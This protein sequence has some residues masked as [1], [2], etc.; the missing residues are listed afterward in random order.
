M[1]LF[2]AA[3][4]T[5]LLLAPRLAFAQESPPSEPLNPDPGPCCGCLIF[6]INDQLQLPQ[7]KDDLVP[8]AKELNG[9]YTI[10]LAVDVGFP[11]QSGAPTSPPPSP[12][13]CSNVRITSIYLVADGPFGWGFPVKV[14]S[15]DG[16]GGIKHY[17]ADVSAATGTVTIPGFKAGIAK[18]FQIKK[19]KV[20]VKCDGTLDPATGVTVFDCSR[21]F[22]LDCGC[23]SCSSGSCEPTAKN[24]CFTVDIPVGYADGGDTS[25]TIR[26]FSNAISQPNLESVM[27]SVP[28]SVSVIRTCQNNLLPH[29]LTN[30]LVD[31]LVTTSTTVVDLKQAHD[32]DPITITQ[33]HA[34]GGDFRVTTVALVSD[35]VNGVTTNHLRADC[36]LGT[37]AIPTSIFRYQQGRDYTP[38]ANGNPAVETYTLDS[39]P[40]GTDSAAAF[41]VMR[42][43]ILKITYNADGTQTHR[44]TV[45]EEAA[46]VSDIAT[47]WENFP[48][49]WEKT[50]EVI[51]PSNG[52]A[53][54]TST[55]SFFA[56]GEN[57]GIP[58]ADETT[59]EGYG[60]LKEYVRY[61]GY[62]ETH[63]Y[64]P[65]N[66]VTISPFAG[67]DD[68][69]TTTCVWDNN[70]NTLTTIR[71]A[72]GN[73]L[74]KV[75][76]NFVDSYTA[77]SITT[78]TYIDGGNP[79]ATPI[80]PGAT[81]ASTETFMP[82]GQPTNVEGWSFGG[83]PK[84]IV[85][86]DGTTTTYTYTRHDTGGG[87]DV[88]QETG[89]ANIGRK[90]TTTYSRFGTPIRS[91][92]KTY[93]YSTNIIL[94]HTA[95]NLVDD[96]GRAITTAYFP[97]VSTAADG[98]IQASATNPAYTTSASYNCCGLESTTDMHGVKTY[99]AYDGLRRRIKTNSLDV[100]TQT[101]HNSLTTETR[102]YPE[103]C[104][105]VL[106][107]T[108]NTSNLTL[109]SRTTRNNLAGT[110]TTTESPDPSAVGNSGALTATLSET[111]YAGGL[112]TVKTT[113]GTAVQLTTSHPD[114]RT[115]QSAGD[116]APGMQYDYVVSGTGLLTTQ[117]HLAGASIATGAIAGTPT[118]A[119]TTQTDRAGRTTDTAKGT[120]T[121]HYSYF[122][123]S[124]DIGSHG[125][126]K[127][128]I[129]HD[130]VLTLYGYNAIGE[131]TTTAINLDGNT[132]INPGTD[133][134][135]RT[136][137]FPA[138][139]TGGT[140]V[141][142]TETCVWQDGDAGANGTPVARTDRTPDG[143]ETWS[144]QIGV[145][146][147]QTATTIG[148]ARTETTTRP[149]NTYTVTTYLGGLPNTVAH[150]SSSG[151]NAI[152]TTI[153]GYG[154]DGLKRLTTCYGPN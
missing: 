90:T 95:V 36:V 14:Y 104:S 105:A 143:L 102:R 103:S 74:S 86:P 72:C 9:N 49:G 135:T 81:L 45:N 12:D 60:Q 11:N 47:T 7:P 122:D 111:V 24:G 35:L 100:T 82:F 120:I 25:G 53:N 130:N 92:E 99:H 118:E 97:T 69:L 129:D 26:F 124:G 37:I 21:P 132:A 73:T 91:L 41:T 110:S 150:F 18:S 154:T 33:S 153:Y 94:A 145:G 131:R 117:S 30:R 116:L 20:V 87:K 151:G 55:W 48:W 98:A 70:K 50:K 128:V 38:A 42:T 23:K 147:F 108:L 2:R 101:T 125:N 85:H 40:V 119:S 140:D 134:V 138:T 51:D 88:V 19:W 106:S 27:I 66:H 15:A 133:Q 5:T 78:K 84:S 62:K 54:L 16:N 6:T 43:E 10:K 121:A 29:S 31:V 137:T 77:P 83:Q 28:S 142:R 76:E 32:Y 17:P 46:T 34:S 1:H 89:T 61:D 63:H 139:R 39:G 114:G 148:L 79:F 152:A 64:W 144:W 141:I 113:V 75:E 57:T 68:G 56:P 67:D 107:S 136:E 93:G 59:T 123:N 44:E 71:T 65:N 149:D 4:L 127:S 80:I 8:A 126:L 58:G 146:E 115:C 22:T 109:I 52:G 112:T 96:F 13:P 3:L